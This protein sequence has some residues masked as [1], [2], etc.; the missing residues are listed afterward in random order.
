MW[1]Y[2]T[3]INKDAGNNTSWNCN[4]RCKLTHTQLRRDPVKV[5]VLDSGKVVGEGKVTALPLFTKPGKVSKLKCDI[6]L[7]GEPAGTVVITGKFEADVPNSE[8]EKK[9]GEA[10]RGDMA[11]SDA[12]EKKQ[13]TAVW[14]I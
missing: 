3:E 8:K 13:I 7:N 1:R 2:S 11:A 12:K 4:V 14:V 10:P 6:S 9:K 5:K